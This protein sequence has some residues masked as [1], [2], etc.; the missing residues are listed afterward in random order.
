MTNRFVLITGCPGGGKSTLLSELASRGF[1]VCDEPGRQI[2]RAEQA[3]GDD[4]LPWLNPAKFAERAARLSI[5][6]LA[7][8]AK[9]G[10][11]TFFDRGL[12]D[13]VC[14]MER[15]GH[16]V[17]PDIADAFARL[18]YA[19]VVFLAPPW[20]E[21]FVTDAERKHGFDDSL[22]EYAHLARRL[23][24]LG[25]EAVLLPKLSV[26][27]RAGFVLSRVSQ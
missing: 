17:P 14:A 24:E 3:S 2:V 15:M 8:A 4:A 13:A 19:P 22:A 11:L 9:R 18:R 1:A 10:G 27:A 23:P 21:I 26:K 6:N 20:P 12:I 25:Y 7:C 5:V 16:A